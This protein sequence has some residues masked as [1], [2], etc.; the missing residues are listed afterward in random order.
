MNISFAIKTHGCKVNQYESQS[1]RESLIKLGCS[2]ADVKEADV[3]IVNSC[4]V[5]G[6]ADSKVRSTVRLANKENPKARI[7]VTG[8][9][10][11]M[12]DDVASLRALPGVTDLV[13]NK[14]KSAIPRI[15]GAMRGEAEPAG[16]FEG[17]SG[18]ASHARAFLKVQDG[19][20]QTCAYCKVSIVRGPSISRS[21]ADV[22]REFELLV[23]KGRREIVLTGICLGA[24]QGE[25][26]RG[27]ADLIEKIEAVEGDFRVRVSSIEPN[28][29]TDRFISVISSSAKICRHLHIPLQSGSDTILALMKRRYNTEQFHALVKKIRHTMPLAGIT[30]DVITG[31]PGETDEDFGHTLRFIN[32]IKPSGL[33]VFG[34]SDRKGTAAHA[35]KDKVKPMAVKS[36][37]KE[38]ERTAEA[39]KREFAEAFVGKTVDVLIEKVDGDT[40]TGYTGEYL[41]A[42]LEGF[43]RKRGDIAKAI[44]GSVDPQETILVANYRE[45]I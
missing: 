10:A 35:M 8:C 12:D 33:H 18:F 20:D 3:I 14:D 5:T 17:V 9:Y 27:I 37:R 19:C 11:V 22:I 39:L 45:Q 38:L 13:H 24:W 30:M 36:R 41:E 15:I 32:E 34:Y 29:V 21:E 6:D 42:R 44:I 31:F 4:T 7:L 25:D 23:S 43:A 26:G 16:G 2:E 1:I 28:Y 40:A